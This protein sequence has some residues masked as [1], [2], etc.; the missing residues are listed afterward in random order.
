M[1]KILLIAFMFFLSISSN[2][3]VTLASWS[4][5]GY[6]QTNSLRGVNIVTAPGVAREF[7]IMFNL[8]KDQAVIFNSFKYEI[9]HTSLN[10]TRTRIPGASYLSYDWKNSYSFN[11]L[12]SFT[13]PA[14]KT[15]GE[16]RLVL[17]SYEGSQKMD[18]PTGGSYSLN[19]KQPPVTPV[20]REGYFYRVT[21]TGM[22]YI[23]MDGKAR[24]IQDANTLHGVFKND[25]DSYISN[26]TQSTFDGFYP[27]NKIGTP[28]GPNTRLVKELNSGWI[29]Y[30]ED[31]V[32]R[33]ITSPAAADKYKFDLNKAQKMRGTDG[34]TYGGSFQ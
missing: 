25:T 11:S 20:N 10:G 21:E 23:N 5:E 6:S 1:K 3:H 30:Q 28:I 27:A 2:A 24:H 18:A 33:H 29:F 32:L 22:V 8:M 31:G 17:I 19:Y 15:E 13:L 4:I 34:Y 7:R 12:F 14:D 16:I 26:I 9:E